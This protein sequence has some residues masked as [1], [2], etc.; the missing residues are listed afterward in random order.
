MRLNYMYVRLAGSKYCC[1]CVYLFEKCQP[2]KIG[3]QYTYILFGVLLDNTSRHF[4]SCVV[5]RGSEKRTRII[6]QNTE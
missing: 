6:D 1:T 4:A 2:K 3:V 5:L